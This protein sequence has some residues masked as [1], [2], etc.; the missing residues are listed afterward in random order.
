MAIKYLEQLELKDKKVIVRF[1]FNVPLSKDGSGKITDTSRIDSALPTINYILAQKP[2]K[3]IMMSHLGRPKDQPEA[4][5][6][7]EPVARYLSKVLKQDV[8]LTES[9]T[10]AGIKTL[11]QSIPTSKII[12]LQNLRF[13]K[14]E[15]AN[16]PEFAKLL[17]SYADVY[18]NDAFGTAHREHASTYGIVG[19]MPKGQ[20]GV[21]LLMKKEIEALSKVS[22]NPTHPFVAIVGG[23][24]VADKIKILESLLVSA[25]TLLIGGAM[26]YPFLKAQNFNVGKSLCG[27]DDVALA[28]KLLASPT[29]KKIKLPVDHLVAENMEGQAQAQNTTDIPANLMGLDIGPKT[30][31]SYQQ[32]L[33]SAKTVLWNGPMGLFENASFAQGTFAIAKTLAELKAFTV[34]GG[35]DSVSAVNQAKVA[36]QLSHV[37]TG[38]GASLEYIEQGTLP[39]IQAIEF[40]VK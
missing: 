35:G 8:T 19:F 7:L 11:L 25:D 5:Y 24:K 2:A 26:A 37:S 9:C 33:K 18:I 14:E 10:D 16:T 32:V 15:T 23:A 22:T 20:C 13:H 3:L 40:G 21:G 1:D 17:A 31:A 29:G 28:K 30:I 38:G 4:K 12:L 36:E 34:V 39:G 6:S 27:D